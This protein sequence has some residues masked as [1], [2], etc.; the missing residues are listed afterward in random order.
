MNFYH[1]NFYAFLFSDRRF[2]N[3]HSDIDGTIPFVDHGK[4]HA[5]RH[6]VPTVGADD[7]GEGRC[8]LVVAGGSRN[9][10]GVG[11][12]EDKEE[13]ARNDGEATRNGTDASH[14]QRQRQKQ[15]RRRIGNRG[16]KIRGR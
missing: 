2:E 10:A 5:A 4:P 15:Q 13:E 16:G 1:F 3:S 12:F 6:F 7:R 14:V 9:S 8:R 11:N